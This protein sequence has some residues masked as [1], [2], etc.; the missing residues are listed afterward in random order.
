MGAYFHVMLGV[1]ALLANFHGV[2][3][4]LP[5]RCRCFVCQ[6]LGSRRKVDDGASAVGSGT[7]MRDSSK[8]GDDRWPLDD[9]RR[10]TIVQQVY[11][12][13]VVLSL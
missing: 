1:V 4:W 7:S 13:G 5:V 2:A 3:L 8:W 6:G 10:A 9:N 12:F 11:R